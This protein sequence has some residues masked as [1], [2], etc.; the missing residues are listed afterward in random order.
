MSEE[1][2]SEVFKIY[3]LEAEEVAQ[4]LRVHT[5]PGDP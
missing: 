1:I 2:H 3:K 5:A 4:Q